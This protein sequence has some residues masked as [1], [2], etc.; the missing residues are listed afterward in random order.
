VPFRIILSILGS[1][2]GLLG[3][4]VASQRVLQAARTLRPQLSIHIVGPPDA[5]KTTLFHYLR[6]ASRID[7]PHRTLVRRRT[8]RIGA[9]LWDSHSSWFRPKIIDDGL[10]R[11]TTQWAKR[12]RTYNP[13]GLIFVV[14]THNPD[15]DRKYFQD[16]Y[17]SYRDFSAHTKRVNLGVLLILLNKFDLW[18]STTDA[19]EA[20]MQ[21]YRTEVCQEVANQ[22]RSTFGIAVQFGYS[23]LTHRE[24]IPYNNL[25]LKGFLTALEHK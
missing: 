9:G 14:D 10:G 6:H 4:S 16:L 7:E 24:H 21:R 20:V 5:G 22:F 11:Q 13:E 1:L 12:L 25:M 17:R 19:R 18:G 15:E 2:A 23:S 8:G 3:I